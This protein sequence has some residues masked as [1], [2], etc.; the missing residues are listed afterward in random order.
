MD[1]S[2]LAGSTVW[3]VMGFSGEGWSSRNATELIQ[4]EGLRI[5]HPGKKILSQGKM[6]VDTCRAT[7]RVARD[8]G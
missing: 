4:Y 8:P 5:A 2:S 6:T 1:T 7:N 3:K